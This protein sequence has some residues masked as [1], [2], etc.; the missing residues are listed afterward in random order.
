[1]KLRLPANERLM[2]VGAVLALIALP[3]LVWSVFDPTVWPLMGALT[4]GQGLGT[5]SFLLYLVVVIRDLDLVNRLK[6]KR[7]QP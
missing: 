4:L 2:R 5:V 3:L 1:M 6:G 7:E